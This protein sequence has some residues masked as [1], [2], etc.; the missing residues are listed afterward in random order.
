MAGPYAKDQPQGFTNRIERVAIVGAGGKMGQHLTEHLLKTGKHIVTAI[1]RPD[2]TSKVPDGVKVAHVNYSGDDLSAL[3]EALKGQQFLLVTMSVMAPRDT[4]S[5]LIRAAAQA[6]VPYI[7]PNWFGHDPS[8][9][10]LCDECF[11]SGINE[12][13]R[14]EI[15]SL[16]VSS[17]IQLCCNFW[18]EFSLGGGP[19]RYGFDFVK[20]SLVL[21]DGGKVAINTSTWAQ[22]GRAVASLLSLK[23]FPDDEADKSTTLSQFRNKPVYIASFLLSQLDMFESVKRVT[24]T[25]DADWTITHES[26]EERWKDSYGAITKGDFSGFTKMLY[27]RTFFPNGGGDYQSSR[28]LDNEVLGLPKEDLDERTAVAI[29]MGEAGEVPF[30]H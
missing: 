25:T 20:R 1:T 28:G 14:T 2:S 3:V 13:V 6:G 10:K 11:L 30:S 5:K 9:K 17:F 22:C 27:S 16:G 15:E 4:M 7:L 21:F 24:G 29:K 12:P 23:E 19:N 26:A 8:N 18:Y